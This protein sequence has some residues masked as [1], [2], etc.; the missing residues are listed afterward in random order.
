[1]KKS[2]LSLVLLAGL[3]LSGAEK[4]FELNGEHG[5][6]ALIGGTLKSPVK[7]ENV[8]LVPG[9][10]NGKAVFIPSDGSLVFSLDGIGKQPEE[11][12]VFRAE[13]AFL[14]TGRGGHSVKVHI[15]GRSSAQ[16]LD[17]FIQYA[18]HRCSS[19]AQ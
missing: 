17:G 3:L 14:F 12:T 11:G 8:K 10:E 4:Q 7:A 16:R 5:L 15:Q 13:N 2:L 6:Q 18:F 1:M 9:M 19:T